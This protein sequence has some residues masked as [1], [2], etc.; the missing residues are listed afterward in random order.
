[1]HRQLKPN[2][3]RFYDRGVQFESSTERTESL[4]LKKAACNASNKLNLEKGLLQN[5]AILTYR[6]N[7]IN[8]SSPGRS[9]S[10]N[11]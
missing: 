8:S 11:K 7:Y 1:M 2:F 3:D 10:P 6:V 9:Q 5:M 4:S